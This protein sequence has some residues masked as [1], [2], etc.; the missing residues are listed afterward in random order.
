MKSR[1]LEMWRKV[2]LC[3]KTLFHTL[4]GEVWWSFLLNVA[5]MTAKPIVQP[6][7]YNS[8]ETNFKFSTILPLFRKFFSIQ[9]VHHSPQKYKNNKKLGLSLKWKFGLDMSF[10]F[11]EL[12]EFIINIKYGS[13][14]CF[15]AQGVACTHGGGPALVAQI[16]NF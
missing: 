4:L 14:E 16:G 10:V 5:T 9:H 12:H 6:L 15:G 13:S 7:S 8:E 2:P 1:N 3:L 11:F